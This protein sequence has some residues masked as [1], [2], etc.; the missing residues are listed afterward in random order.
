MGTLFVFAQSGIDLFLNLS[1]RIEETRI[2]YLGAK[3]SF[4]VRAT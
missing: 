3:A 2:K 1:D 4:E